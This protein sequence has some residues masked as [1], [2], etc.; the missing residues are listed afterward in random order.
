MNS[1]NLIEPIPPSKQEAHMRWVH[2]TTFSFTI[3]FI[4]TSIWCIKL[5][6]NYVALKK[7][8]RN[9]IHLIKNIAPKNENYITLKNKVELLKQ[10][11]MALSSIKNKKKSPLL[12]LNEI[13]TLIPEDVHLVGYEQVSKKILLDTCALS[14][15]SIIQF[16]QTLEQSC[17]IK[18]CSL[19]SFDHADKNNHDI[20]RCQLQCVIRK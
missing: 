7:K 5:G 15:A 20:I 14:Y 4:V 9:L 17:H 8:E 1:I 18:K 11:E 16:I 13:A 19:L 12:F 10:K 2:I 6:L 3:F